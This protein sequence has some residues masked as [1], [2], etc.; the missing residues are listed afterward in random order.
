MA[1]T[2]LKCTLAKSQQQCE[3][4]SLTTIRNHKI[5]SCQQPHELE[6]TLLPPGR[7]AKINT[8]IFA[9]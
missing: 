9:S 2:I 6:R 8:L 3:D 1:S 5:E 7:N 4:L